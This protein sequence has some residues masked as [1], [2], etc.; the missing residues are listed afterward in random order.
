MDHS[1]SNPRAGAIRPDSV[2]VTPQQYISQNWEKP[3]VPADRR[4]SQVWGRSMDFDNIG[5]IIATRRLYFVDEN[6]NKRT[7]SVLVGKTQEAQDSIGYHCPFQVIGIGNQ[8][9]RLA[10]GHDSIQALQSA[11]I[12]IAA[13][14]H[15]LNNEIGGKLAWEGGRKG[16]LGFP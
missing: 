4:R 14:L 2:V 3:R 12:L 5:E 10:R 11:L 8:A 7:V 16:E 9:T 13:S 1:H 6:N 15:H